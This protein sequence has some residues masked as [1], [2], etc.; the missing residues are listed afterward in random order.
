M[1]L[2]LTVNKDSQYQSVN[3]LI[4]C[5]EQDTDLPKNTIKIIYNYP[6]KTFRCTSGKKQ[7]ADVS[8]ARVCACVCV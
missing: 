1:Y 3:L 6:S 7:K 5:T 8:V 4:V 2:P